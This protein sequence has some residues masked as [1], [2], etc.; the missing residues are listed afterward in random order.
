MNGVFSSIF[1]LAP[2]ACSEDKYRKI[3]SGNMGG[4][5]LVLRV[6]S[7]HFSKEVF[8]ILEGNGTVFSR[9]SD[10][11]FITMELTS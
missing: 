11:L 4:L 1:G 3:K 6:L 2:E 5:Y 10:A 8:I 7:V 9:L